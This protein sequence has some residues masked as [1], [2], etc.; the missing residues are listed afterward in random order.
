MPGTN[1]NKFANLRVL[2]GHM[3]SQAAKKLLFMGGEFGQ[4]AEWAH[5]GQLQW[6][7]LDDPL[8]RGMQRWVADLNRTYRQ[9]PR[10]MRGTSTRL[11]SNG[12]IARMS[13]PA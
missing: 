2:F 6:D 1:G 11:A 9:E 8:H 10:C 4:Q 7:T 5:D 13:N 12:S 3:Y